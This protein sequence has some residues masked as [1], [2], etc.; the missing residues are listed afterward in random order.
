MRIECMAHWHF[1]RGYGAGI[2]SCMTLTAIL[3]DLISAFAMQP[4]LLVP[5]I[6]LA[7]LVLEDVATITVGVLASRMLVDP[8]IAVTS[9]VIGTALG[10]IG[11]YLIAR[12]ARNWP[13]ARGI[14]RKVDTT[15]ITR[16]LQQHAMVMLVV[17]R[18]TPG[19]RIPIFAGAGALATPFLPFCAVIIA[20]TL[21]WTPGLYVLASKADMHLITGTGSW[22]WIGFVILT[23]TLFVL[24]HR[25][26]KMLATIAI[27]T[28]RNAVAA[29]S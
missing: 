11:L 3:P 12:R 8:T 10:D 26:S 28:D 20:T 6:V 18:F 7:T 21:L 14:M 9:L 1:Y 2:A 17:A 19:T 24:A 27:R 4:L 22:G 13:F 15:P 25:A 16:W 29:A 5:I 23:V